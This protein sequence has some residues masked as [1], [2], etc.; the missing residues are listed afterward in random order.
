[1]ILWTSL[2]PIIYLTW[3]DPITIKSPKAISF[4]NG[5]TRG[6]FSIKWLS[7]I[8]IRTLSKRARTHQKPAGKD[9]NPERRIT[10][11]KN[12][13][14][15]LIIQNSFEPVRY[16]STGVHGVSGPWAQRHFTSG[17]RAYNPEPRLDNHHTNSCKMRYTKPKIPN[18]RPSKSIPHENKCETN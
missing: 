11:N 8:I 7:G 14:G 5:I 16:K 13:C 9:H 4:L 17:E 10:N 6:V 15:R 12:P 2:T 1:M 3:F 18:P